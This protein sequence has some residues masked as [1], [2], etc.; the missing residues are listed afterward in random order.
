MPRRNYLTD[1]PFV[2]QVWQMKRPHAFSTPLDPGKVDG[3][4]RE[5]RMTKQEFARACRIDPTMI[6]KWLTG[7]R[8]PNAF[9]VGVMAF[10]LDVKPDEITA[11][12]ECVKAAA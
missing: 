10:V 2:W 5:L 4:L 3:R 7:H 8:I 9:Q 12:C 1:L 11:Q 6:S